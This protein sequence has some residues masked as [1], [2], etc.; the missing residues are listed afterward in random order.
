MRRPLEVSSS[1]TQ[2]Q[3]PN[4]QQDSSSAPVR[5]HPVGRLAGM[6]LRRKGKEQDNLTL[7]SSTSDTNDE[8]EQKQPQRKM[9]KEKS[10]RGKTKLS[11]S[12][13]IVSVI[14]TINDSKPGATTLSERGRRHRADRKDSKKHSESM[15]DLVDRFDEIVCRHGAAFR[16]SIGHQEE[17]ESYRDDVGLLEQ[18]EADT[19][20]DLRA[21]LEDCDDFDDDNENVGI[22]SKQLD[23]SIFRPYL[24]QAGIDPALVE[25]L[26]GTKQK[27]IVDGC[28][29]NSLNSRDDDFSPPSPRV[30]LAEQQILHIFHD[31]LSTLYEESSSINRESTDEDSSVLTRQSS[32]TLSDILDHGFHHQRHHSNSPYISS[33]PSTP[34]NPHRHRSKS[35]SSGT[36]DLKVRARWEYALQ[37]M[38]NMEASGSSAAAAAAAHLHH[39]G[40]FKRIAKRR[41]MKSGKSGNS[42]SSSGQRRSSRHRRSSGSHMYPQHRRHQLRRYLQQQHQQRQLQRQQMQGVIGPKHL[43]CSPPSPGQ[44][45]PPPPP[46]PPS[47]TSKQLPSSKEVKTLMT[48]T[49]L[50][51]EVAEI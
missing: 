2:P 34:T 39:P 44:Q 42:T 21:L 17:D 7:A 29:E 5:R 13:E 31:E 43:L 35:Q 8:N 51:G 33:P 19:G 47:T 3:A 14:N 30:D 22:A 10:N 32:T 25:A 27:D 4:D 24:E 45:S 6:L 18:S 28:K 1:A 49:S 12:A 20:M 41:F 15:D 40:S 9:S 26:A 23:S 48:E 38:R 36:D 11:T 37:V 46:P 16:W 50:L